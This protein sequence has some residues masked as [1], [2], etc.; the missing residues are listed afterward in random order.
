MLIFQG[1]NLKW[2]LKGKNEKFKSF[3]VDPNKEKIFIIMDPSHMVKL[4][5]NRLA[6][7]GKFID[8]DGNKI[9]WRYIAA[10]YEYSIKHGLYTHK[11]TKKHMEWKRQ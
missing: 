2:N 6:S 1:A 9:E 10:L 11:L 4:I 7:C 5:R 8:A 3:I